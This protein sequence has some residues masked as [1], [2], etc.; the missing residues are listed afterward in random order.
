MAISCGMSEDLPISLMLIGKLFDEAS[1]ELLDLMG[2]K[3]WFSREHLID[4]NAERITHDIPI[5]GE[6]KP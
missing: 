6:L 3:V 2:F 5:I 4:H 1:Q